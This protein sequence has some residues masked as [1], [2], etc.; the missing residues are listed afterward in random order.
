MYVEEQVKNADLYKPVLN[1]IKTSRKQCVK[2]NFGE[3]HAERHM[4]QNN[5]VL[6][7]TSHETK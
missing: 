6:C 1:K 7:R 4:R 2:Y 5:K 3:S